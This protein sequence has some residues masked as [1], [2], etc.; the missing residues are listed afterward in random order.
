[1]SQRTGEIIIII[2][3]ILLN[4]LVLS[5]GHGGRGIDYQEEQASYEGR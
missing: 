3:V 2:I 4:I 1:M 5:G